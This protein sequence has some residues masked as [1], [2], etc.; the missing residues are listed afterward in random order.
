MFKFLLL[1]AVLSVALAFQSN[2]MGT[3]TGLQIG[4]FVASCL[5]RY[6]HVL[7]IESC[8]TPHI[9]I[10]LR[11]HVALPTLANSLQAHSSLPLSSHHS[12]PVLLSPLLPPLLSTLL[13]PL[14]LNRCHEDLLQDAG[15]GQEVRGG[16]HR[17]RPQGQ[18]GVRAR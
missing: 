1:L 14:C 3:W 10:S 12:F 17:G 2:R 13:P 11:L 6:S 15:D 16:P 7:V 18:E 4:F 5:C 9:S 8:S